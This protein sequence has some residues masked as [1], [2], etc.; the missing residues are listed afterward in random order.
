MKNICSLKELFL[1]GNPCTNIEGY[2][3]YVIKNL[4]QLVELDGTKINTHERILAD[5]D[6]NLDN[7]VYQHQEKLIEEDKAMREKY[8]KDPENNF[9]HCAESRL[10]HELA[11]KADIDEKNVIKT[12]EDNQ[13]KK[14]QLKTPKLMCEKTGEPL[15]VNQLRLD[16][17]IEYEG[18]F[19][20]FIVFTPKY[21]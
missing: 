3:L 19:I 14:Y 18:E 6:V 11:I 8:I 1:T 13:D 12:N 7:T 4:K 5:K 10:D 16:F 9:Y 2:R 17:K 15:N 21:F 20:K